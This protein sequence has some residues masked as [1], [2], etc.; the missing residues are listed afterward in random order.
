MPSTEVLSF[1]VRRLLSRRKDS[2]IAYSQLENAQY[3]NLDGN[4]ITPKIVQT[5]C[6]CSSSV[7]HIKMQVFVQKL[8]LQK[9]TLDIRFGD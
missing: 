6:A 4:E 7:L 8:F 9:R 3:I 5:I 1:A 2:R